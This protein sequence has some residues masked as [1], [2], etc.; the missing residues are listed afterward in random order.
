MSEQFTPQAAILWS[1]ISKE[2]QQRVLK[3]VFCGKCRTSVEMVQFTG[4][5]EQGKII[6]EEKLGH[7][8]QWHNSVSK[9]IRATAGRASE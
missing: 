5:V 2:N 7:W 1:A 3:N 6:L 8:H 4:K 9:V